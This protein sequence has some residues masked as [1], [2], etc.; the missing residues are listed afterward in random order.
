MK[1]LVIEDSPDDALFVVRALRSG[2]EALD[3]ERV[4]SAAALIAA[5]RRQEWDVI[6]C[7]WVMPGFGALAALD[8]LRQE[9]VDA[10]IIIVTGEVGEEFAVTAMRAGAHD[11]V[12]KHRLAR[13][14][15][16]VDREL[17]ETEVRRARQR[18]ERDLHESEDRYRDLVEHSHDLICTHDLQGRILSVNPAPARMLDYTPGELLTM[19]LADILAPAA[20]ERLPE[21]FATLGR[22]RI[23]TGVMAIQ[24]RSG[25]RR[26]WEY[27]NT[28][29]TEGVSVPIVRG[30][31]HDV[32]ERRRAEVLLRKSEEHFRALTEHALDLVLIL[33]PDS[34]I[35]YAS[36]SHEKVLGFSA[37]ELAGQLAFDFVHP[38]DRAHVW[39]RFAETMASHA[40]GASV[41]YRLRCKDG[42]WTVAEA[43]AK[44]LVDDPIVGGILVTAR[45]IGERV[46]AAETLRSVQ[47]ASEERFRAM[48]EDAHDAV[49]LMAD[50]GRILYASPGIVRV[51]GYAPDDVVGRFGLALVAPDD[52]P[53]MQAAFESMLRHPGQPATAEM[54]LRHRDGSVRWIEAAGRSALD[55]PSVRG[56]VLNLRDVTGRERAA[57]LLRKQVRQQ[58]ALVALGQIVLAA[59]PLSVVFDAAARHA[60][61]TL[62]IELSVVVEL[63]HDGETLLS[64][65][66]VGW[67]AGL[68]GHTTVGVGTASHAGYTLH[69][70]APVVLSD[71][72]TETRFAIPPVLRA[73]DVVSG[74]SVPVVSRERPF[75]ALC[76]Y[77][78]RPRTFSRDEVSLLRGL[79]NTIAAAIQQD[80]IALALEGRVQDRTAQLEAA[81]RELEAF[82]Y[83]VS[84]DLRAPLRA[85]DGFGRLLLEDCAARLGEQGRA[86]LAHI[87][88]STAR[89]Q[90]LIDGLL[91]LAQVSR[92][93]VAW[94]AV[95]LSALA[96]AVAADLHDPARTVDVIIATDLR[97][98][99][100][101]RLLRVVLQNL[102]GNAWKYTS[103][104]ARG[105]IEFGAATIDGGPSYF[106]RDDGAGFD[107]RYAARLF[108]AFQRLHDPA[109][110]EGAGIGLAT[111]QRIIHRHGGRVWAAG[112]P[113][114]GATFFFTLG[115]PPPDAS[116]VG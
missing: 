22:D 94:T 57:A 5:V 51:L 98:H 116:G 64:R 24:T 77:S 83:S 96:A 114:Q 112:A 69:T 75:G 34:T 113:G 80:R 21:Y 61:E 88:G 13:L 46:R 16:A 81:N 11:F 47:R 26:L 72:R 91:D 74:L 10:P 108:V 39:A 15:P 29:R 78:R 76:V 23:A 53:R 48:V 93:A 73:H 89:M 28:L 8:I 62:E 115:A 68:V 50:D 63:L 56:V 41:Q 14:R 36:P 84:H 70:G 4:D 45:D 38:D 87:R 102:L 106:V 66:G 82:S 31:A 44:N 90:E 103:K 43:V 95:D 27:T 71:L 6:T 92:G 49:L 111:V 35:R 79:G 110:F 9:Q 58:E 19:N 107:P 86:H 67:A 99:G 18:A 1:L 20:R 85:I 7:D 42:S 32:T 54:R 52:K 105:R 33:E 3:W 59:P 97:A 55:N 40:V 101:Q 60:A 104:Q 2:G 30:M 109:E 65:A 12:S 37:E 25:Q 100:D 17:R